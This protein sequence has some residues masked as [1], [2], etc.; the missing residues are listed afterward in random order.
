MF[1]KFLCLNGL[2]WSCCQGLWIWIRFHHYVIYILLYYVIMDLAAGLN[3]C[4][5]DTGPSVPRSRNG[6]S[7]LVIHG[8]DDLWGCLEPKIAMVSPPPRTPFMIFMGKFQWT[9]WTSVAILASRYCDRP[10][11]CASG[12]GR[13]TTTWDVF[14]E[15]R[16]QWRILKMKNAPTN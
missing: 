6:L 9:Q 8:C 5:S 16:P 3:R 1:W 12:S 11:P 4:G 15:A 14:L 7:M 10:W 13:A 2:C